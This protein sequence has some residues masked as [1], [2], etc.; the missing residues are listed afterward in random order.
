MESRS[1]RLRPKIISSALIILFG[2]SAR[3][4]PCAQ[5]GYKVPA[6]I[7]RSHY[8]IDA[9]VDL[10]THGAIEGKETIV[11]KNSAQEEIEMIALDWSI[12][13]DSALSVSIGGEEIAPLNPE[14]LAA[15]PSPLFFRLPKPLK[16]GKKIEMAVTFKKPVE[17]SPKDREFKEIRWYPRLWWDGLPLHD[18]FSVKFD[19]PAGFALAASGRLNPK[20]G[21]YENE[22]AK[23]FGIYLGKDMKM[24][25]RE[26]DGVLVT[27]VA[28]E[29]GAKCAAISLETAVDVIRFC[30]EWLGFYPFK[31]LSIIPG[32]SGRYGGYPF[33]TGIVVIHGQETFKEGEPT[34]WWQWIT[35][36]EIG[37]EYWGEWVLDPDDP[38]WL[39]I[40]MGI[41][42][43]TEYLIARGIDPERRRKWMTDYLNGLPMY[44]DMT[45]DIPPAR[46]EKIQYDHNNT[47]VH[48][49]GPS[50]IFAL[51]AVLGRDA[52]MKL[53][54][55]CLRECGGKRL[56]WREFQRY[57]EKETGQSLAWFFEQWVRTNSYLCYKIENK[58]CIQEGDEYVS[59]VKVRCLG[60][61]KMPVPVRAVFE[62]GSEQVQA[63]NRNFDVDSLVFR[64]RAKLQEAVLDPDKKFAMVDEPVPPISAAAAEMLSLGW[65]GKD[66]P[67]V[68][69]AIKD[70]GIENKETWY[71][72]GMQ[73]FELGRYPESFD[74][75][76]K[77]SGLQRDGLEKFAALGWMGLLQDLM[78]KRAS[79]L[80]HYREALKYDTGKPMGHS[81]LRIRI[82]RPWLEERLRTPFT[83]ESTVEIPAQPTAD[84]LVQIVDDLN[85]TREGKTPLFV[86]EKARTL[87]V[88]DHNFW[89]KLGLL[90]FDSGYYPQSFSAFEKLSALAP[91]ELSKFTALVW[92]GQ[93]MDLQGK[94]ERAVEYYR[95]ALE[96]DPG[97]TMTHSQYGM[98]INRRWVEERLERP[99]VWKK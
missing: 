69:Q 83:I 98:K 66:S 89:L 27:T 77:V 22:G 29:K 71:R 49:K 1:A 61:M 40:G 37:H 96:H 16:R 17:F 74:C 24:E 36:H 70:A 85:W 43:D 72:L 38:A 65:E 53:Y 47:V 93:L 86:F 5:E 63:V 11:F 6:E 56:A 10:V 76:Q 75:F 90:L 41:F 35:A 42:I 52:F 57:C 94:R 58:E 87:S 12:G 54:R 51:D 4:S 9:Q 25:S 67:A 14:S 48:S 82:D 20:T 21:R 23:T 97:S 68:Y 44:Y 50:I 15:L 88:S 81:Y 19:I 30:G 92:M 73:L 3:P 59:R 91:S 33:A 64:S 62:D 32:G 31:F 7:P 78:G 46:L 84:Q 13:P 45:V 60:T 28:T 26:V 79:A 55:K 18:S 34:L 2:L 39:W 80:A 8:R 99:F 95:Q